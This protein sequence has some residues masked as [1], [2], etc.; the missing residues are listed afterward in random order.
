MRAL[1]QVAVMKKWRAVTNERMT[2][3]VGSTSKLTCCQSEGEIDH[4]P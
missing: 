4:N 2:N 1:P 3:L